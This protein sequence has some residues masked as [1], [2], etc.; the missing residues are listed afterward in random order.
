MQLIRE[1]ETRNARGFA[2]VTMST[3]EEV[4]IGIE[5]F[6]QYVSNI[7]ISSCYILSFECFLN[8]MKI[9]RKMNNPHPYPKGSVSWYNT[10]A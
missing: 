8:G 4:E 5:K 2:F 6:N 9:K 10:N 7:F 3:A 1:R